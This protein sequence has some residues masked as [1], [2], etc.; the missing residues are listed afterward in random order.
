MKKSDLIKLLAVETGGSIQ[1]SEKYFNALCGQIQKLL[2]EGEEVSLPG[3]GK[4]KVVPSAGRIARNPRTGEKLNVPP[5]KKVQFYR[6]AKIKAL[7][8]S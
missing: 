6:S 4:L 8:Q 5:G 7:L 3:V 2:V 1:H